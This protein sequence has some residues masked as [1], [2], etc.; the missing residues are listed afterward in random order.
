MLGRVDHCRVGTKSAPKRRIVR[1][2][3]QRR[4]R[5]SP[6]E[7]AFKNKKKPS[8]RN[9]RL[10]SRVLSFDASRRASKLGARNRRTRS[11]RR[12]AVV[13]PRWRLR[14]VS[15]FRVRAPRHDTPRRARTPSSLLPLQHH[16]DR[17]RALRP[18][19]LRR[20]GHL[21]GGHPGG[22]G[23]VRVHQARRPRVEDERA[24]RQPHDVFQDAGRVQ[25]LGVQE[26]LPRREAPLPLPRHD[27]PHHGEGASRV[28]SFATR[29]GG[30]LKRRLESLE[31]LPKTV[32]ASTTKGRHERDVRRS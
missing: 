26:A 7:N 32:D 12:F 5:F 17:L 28:L 14:R 11:A 18:G 31:A 9:T 19:P 25:P 13:A 6:P 24:A 15:E 29:R 23:G 3:L 22:R 30:V 20:G 27:P 1:F 16:G 10:V 8:H 4:S 21:P 2:S